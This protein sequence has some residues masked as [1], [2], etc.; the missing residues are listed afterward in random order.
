MD[1]CYKIKLPIMR[2]TFNAVL[3]RLGIDLTG[4]NCG[5]MC[6]SVS[7]SSAKL[8]VVDTEFWYFRLC[9]GLN[10]ENNYYLELPF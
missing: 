8:P 10:F 7:S 4:G 6:V 2:R 5:S 1:G 9:D 3:Q